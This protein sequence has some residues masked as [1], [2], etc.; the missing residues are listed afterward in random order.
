MVPVA[1]VKASLAVDMAAF[2][3]SSGYGSEPQGSMALRRDEIGHLF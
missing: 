1:P 3:T 2:T